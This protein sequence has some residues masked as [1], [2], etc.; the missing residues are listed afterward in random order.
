VVLLGSPVSGCLAADQLLP[1]RVGRM[2]I[3]RALLQWQ[4]EHGREVTARL[5]VGAIAGTVRMGIGSLIVKLPP[6]N[7]GVV[8]VDETRVPGLADHVVMRTSHSGMAVSA[9]AARQIAHFLQHGRFA[10]T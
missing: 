10:H 2:L 3:G 9:R 8:T 6:P 5:Q 1:S 4:A 7:D